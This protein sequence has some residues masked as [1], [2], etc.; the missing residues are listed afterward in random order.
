[1]TRPT[2]LDALSRPVPKRLKR[3]FRGRRRLVD[4][5]ARLEALMG[6]LHAQDGKPY[7]KAANL[8]VLDRD[9]AL[10]QARVMGAAPYVPC[11][12]PVEDRA[13]KQCNA[14]RWQTGIEY[15]TASSPEPE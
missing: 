8:A 7:M 11:F 9:A 5:C 15:L 12:C 3:V 13:C 2:I 10:M 4:W 1:V 6:E 14:K